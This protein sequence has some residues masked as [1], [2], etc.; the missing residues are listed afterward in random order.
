MWLLKPRAERLLKRNLGR[1][2]SRL[3]WQ[4]PYRGHRS[5]VVV[6]RQRLKLHR[7]HSLRGHFHRQ[8]AKHT[9]NCSNT[10]HSMEA[11]YCI[12]PGNRTYKNKL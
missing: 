6:Q 8:S 4:L 3:S 12:P 1:A 7:T 10:G 2:L 9:L 11:L 5:Y